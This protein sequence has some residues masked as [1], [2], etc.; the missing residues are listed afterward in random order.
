M[1]TTDMYNEIKELN[2]AY[3]MLAQQMLREDRETAMFRLGLGEEIASIIGRLTPGQLL[4]MAATDML[5]CRFRFDDSLI[6][7]LL[8]N[9]QRDLGTAHLHAAILAAGKPVE[10]LA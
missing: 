5:L 6:L 1:N 2:L 3:L 4:K 10:A 9:H 8:S 7:D